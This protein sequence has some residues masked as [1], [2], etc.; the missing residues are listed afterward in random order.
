M[1]NID[2]DLENDTDFTLVNKLAM[3][4]LPEVQF[5]SVY[6]IAENTSDGAQTMFNI[7]L[8]FIFQ[9]LPMTYNL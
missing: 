6:R 1:K 2:A 8:L 4:Q 7:Y 5:Q 3:G 9:I